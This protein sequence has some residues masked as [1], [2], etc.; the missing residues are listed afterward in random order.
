VTMTSVNAKGD[1]T[2]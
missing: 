2:S 1:I